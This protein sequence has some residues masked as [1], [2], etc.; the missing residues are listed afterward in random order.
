MD[1]DPGIVKN[2][3]AVE[4]NSPILL[5]GVA[6]SSLWRRQPCTRTVYQL[7]SG[8]RLTIAAK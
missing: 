2:Y 1:L 7:S 8:V 4:L 3:Q 5:A 6:V